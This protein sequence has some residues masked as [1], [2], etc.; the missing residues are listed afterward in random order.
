[1]VLGRAPRPDGVPGND[2]EGAHAAQ[3][4]RGGRDRRE[5]PGHGMRGMLPGLREGLQA[6]GWQPAVQRLPHFPLR[7]EADSGEADRLHEAAAAEDRLPRRVPYVPRVKGLRAS[8]AGPQIH[9]RPEGPRDPPAPRGRVVLRRRRGLPRSLSGTSCGRCAAPARCRGGHRR[10]GPRDDV[11]PRRDALRGRG[12]STEHDVE[13]HRPRRDARERPVTDPQIVKLRPH[14][15]ECF[16]LG[17]VILNWPP[18]RSSSHSS[19]DPWRYVR[20]FGS[21]NTLTS[22]SATTMSVGRAAS[23]R[24]IRYCI[25]LHPP[26]MM[27]RRSE[28]AGFFSFCRSTRIRRTALSVTVSGSCWGAIKR[29][30]SRIVRTRAR[31][32][33]LPPQVARSESVPRHSP[34]ARPKIYITTL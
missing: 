26:A 27:R 28:A 13:H 15:Q 24:S 25:P 4:Q 17:F 6:V 23:A 14:E 11:P 5:G 1:M 31:D 3:C 2:E 10:D 30:A 8:E 29:I 33:S 21:T 7:R 18:N 20:L 12:P 32:L 34:N 16:A 9:S 19:F 22:C